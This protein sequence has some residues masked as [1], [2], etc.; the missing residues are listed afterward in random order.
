MKRKLSVVVLL[1]LTSNAR[2]IEPSV[3]AIFPAGAQRGT[4][5]QFKVLGLYLHDGCEFEMIS[6]SGSIKASDRI[7]AA[8][9]LH[10]DQIV[11]P[12]T[13]FSY[14]NHVF[15]EYEGTATVAADTP[16]GMAYWGVR[17][18]Q[19]ITGLRPFMVGDYPEIIEEEISGDP[20]PELVELPVTINGRIYPREDVDVWSVKATKGQSVT[21]EVW[22]RRLGSTLVPSLEVRDKNGKT[23]VENIGHFSGDPFVRFVA[24]QDGTYFVRIH[25]IRSGGVLG[26]VYR[27]AITSGPYVDC[28]YPLGGRRGEVTAFELVG[29]ATP[30]APVEIA[31]PGDGRREFVSRLELDGIPTN[32]FKID[33]GDLPEYLETEP[34]NQPQEGNSFS[35]PAVLNGR[36]DTKDDR[37][38][39]SVDAR[40]GQRVLIEF[41]A[42]RPGSSLDPELVLSD[43]SGKQLLRNTADDPQL[44]EGSADFTFPEDGTYHL[45]VEELFGGRGGPDF[46]YRLQIAFP[47]PPP[48]ADFSLELPTLRV[49]LLRGKSIELTVKARREG[50]LDGDIDLVIEGLPAGVT[51]APTKIP[52]DK[53]EVK[54]KFSSAQETYAGISRVKIHGSLKTEETTLTR[55]ATKTVGNGPMTSDTLALA[56][57]LPAPF[58]FTAIYEL[59]FSLH[60]TIHHR[61]YTLH[62][63]GY[64]G[65]LRAQL[66][67]TQLRHQQGS[68]GPTITI[69]AGA[70]EFHYPLNVSLW[71]QVGLTSRTVIMISADIEENGETYTVAYSSKD[72]KHQII[73][74]PNAGPI[75]VTADKPT[76]LFS[77]DNPASLGIKVLR[78]PALQAPIRVELIPAAHVRGITAKSIDI[79]KGEGG[80][81][82]DIHFAEDAGPFN[83]P[84][85]LRATL[86]PIETVTVRGRPLHKGDPIISE[87]RFKVAPAQFRR[88]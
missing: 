8:E 38:T 7:E 49:A 72:A 34:N 39:W 30:D 59:P 44:Q 76:V 26:S 53:S 32:E 19:G 41:R 2:A 63:G 67:S 21:C 71:A 6:P 3:S 51:A 22:T 42:R 31:L 52:K 57:T 61:K 55:T 54:I 5:V 77:P 60:G 66:A 74:Q 79:R 58:K 75:G 12:H 73:M 1:A 24:P 37:D 28:P 25:D 68:Y 20:I 15:R 46:V 81:T 35:L 47:K 84:L 11:T 45:R 88:F 43:S 69:P 16:V 50:G 13:Y 85:V 83:A 87:T 70:T 56:T 4:T 78:D 18:G 36:I 82:L 29:Q 64:E 9:T 86:Y 33:L 17:T 48:A 23:L 80:G 10:F 62:R 65:P 27:L 14:E 40:K